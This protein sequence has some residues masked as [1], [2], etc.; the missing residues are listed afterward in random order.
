MSAEK[1]MGRTVSKRLSAPVAHSGK[2]SSL[3]IRYYRNGRMAGTAT[4]GLVPAGDRL[5]KAMRMGG[6]VCSKGNRDAG[7]HRSLHLISLG[8]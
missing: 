7:F 5:Q 1:H 3:R 4:G 2:V 6:P 8:F